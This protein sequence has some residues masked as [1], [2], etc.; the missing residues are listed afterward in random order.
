MNFYNIFQKYVFKDAKI[1]E[2]GCNVG[3]IT[4]IIN[5]NFECKITG[6]DNNEIFES[7]FNN[8]LNKKAIFK[9][10]DFFSNE[11]LAMIGKYDLIFFRDIFNSFDQKYHQRILD[12][13]IINNCLK[14]T[15]IIINEFSSV[16]KFTHYINKF[17][18]RKKSRRLNFLNIKNINLEKVEIIK[19]YSGDFFTKK[20]KNII[21]KIINY[22]KIYVLKCIK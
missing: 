18:L 10:V 5:D 3:K 7:D 11:D 19:I 8:L 1:L 9:K 6:I 2:I 14:N 16:T 22:K 4:K 15:I 13:I 21:Y 20:Y 17:L 12:N